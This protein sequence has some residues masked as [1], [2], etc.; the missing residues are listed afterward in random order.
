MNN[1]LFVDMWITFCLQS[2]V[3]IASLTNSC[4]KKTRIKDYKLF[5]FF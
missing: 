4:K 1:Y 2:I 3:F 5:C